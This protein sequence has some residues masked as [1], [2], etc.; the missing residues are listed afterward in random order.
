[1]IK[2]VDDVLAGRIL[3]GKKIRLA[4]ERFKRDLG[5]SKT[6]EF[7]Y[8]YDEEE[9]TKAVK[10]IESLPKTDGSKLDMQPFQE[11]I[12][13]ELYGWKEKDTEFRRY[14]RA[15]ISM[16]RKN[17]KTYLAS[18]IAANGLLRE[19]SPA[20][21]RQVLFVSNGLK[22]AKLGYNMLSSGLNQVRKKSKYMRQRIKVQKQEVEDLES[23]SKAIALASDTST[24]D[25]FAGTT[26]VLDEWHEAKDR[27]V[28]NVLK[29]GQAQEDNS[30]LAVISTSGLNLNVPMHAEYE[31]LNDVLNGKVKADRYFVAIWELDDR[32][33]VYDQDNWIKANPLFSEPS[34]KKKM[35]EKIQAD[36][37]LAIKQNN[38]I[39]VLVKNF[40][41]WLQ[42]SE[43]SYISADDWSAG[44]VESI[45]LNNRDI[46]IGVDLSKSND[47]TAVSWVIP[48]GDGHFYC[49]SHS[50]VGT[51]YGLDSKI[52]RDGIDYRS[53]ERAK[54]CTI[55]RLESGIIDYDA[56]FEY[57]Q[58]II[59]KYNF[60]VKAI[61]YDPYNFDALLT[62]FEKANYPLF[63]VRQGTKTLNIPTRDFREK[64]YDG[65][66]QHNGNKILAYAVNNAIL[67][68]DNNGWQI[69]KARNSNRID[70]IAALINAYVAGMDYYEESEANQHAN[71]YYTSAEF[72]F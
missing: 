66:I 36:V 72:S 70:P 71:D 69:D 30:L 60:R 52:K 64:L 48:T 34:V 29:S 6:D 16:A 22:Q 9:A 15:F 61:A 28:Y 25:G 5:R 49:D 63:E 2:Y 1:M 7:N 27:K 24:L 14:D 3:V 47:L 32:E 65:K 53:M 55:T 44:K 13:S 62:K 50:W 20:M 4:C 67:K 8:Y 42:A 18:G 54:E 23:G 51:K 33:E 38:M 40:N 58:S 17:G 39:P 31:M 46:Y 37:D 10:F 43:D 41:M 59:G 19:K 26:I 11:W 45:N 56:V 68:V 35:T 57:I 21:N 12:I